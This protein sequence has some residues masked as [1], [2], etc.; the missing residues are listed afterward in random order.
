[1]T[2]GHEK[3][4]FIIK[5]NQTWEVTDLPSNKIA[6]GVKWVFRTKLNPDCTVFKNKASVGYSTGVN[7]ELFKLCVINYFSLLLLPS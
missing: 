5:K 1:M 7:V 6:I 3:W 2:W 4:D